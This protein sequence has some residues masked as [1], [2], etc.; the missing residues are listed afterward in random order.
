MYCPCELVSTTDST[1]SYE[2][3]LFPDVCKHTK[4]QHHNGHSS[5]WTK[6][7]NGIH[8]VMIN[9]KLG[10]LTAHN[11]TLLMLF[12]EQDSW[13]ELDELLSVKIGNDQDC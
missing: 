1:I 6:K 7:R 13:G 4:D 2:T 3:K 8:L 10:N 9:N 11:N 5:A 12:V